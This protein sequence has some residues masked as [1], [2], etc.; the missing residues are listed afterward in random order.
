[1]TTSSVAAP[2]GRPIIYI[3][4]SSDQQDTARQEHGVP[5]LA[6]RDFPGVEP[7]VIRDD[8][9]SAYRNSIAERRGG[10]ELLRLIEHHDIPVVYADSQD[11]ISRGG[12]AE[13]LTFTA[14]CN[15]RRTRI[16]TLAGGELDTTS[17]ESELVG[18]V[19]SW[20]SKRESA[21][22]EHRS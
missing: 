10:A 13:W 14:L 21:E 12:P 19:L 22:K 4:V 6:I 18:S 20:L 2:D 15:T 8:G 5:E 3:R 1:V 7:I 16:H 11:R 9:V 17:P